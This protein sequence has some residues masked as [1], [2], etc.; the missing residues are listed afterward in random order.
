MALLALVGC[1]A[2]FDLTRPPDAPLDPD[3]PISC[4]LATTHDEDGDGVFDA[5]DNCPTLANADQANTLETEDGE[6]ADSVGDVCDPN[7]TRSGDT[8]VRAVM[9]DKTSDTTT[10]QAQGQWLHQ[11]DV[12][13]YEPVTSHTEQVLAVDSRAMPAPPFTIETNVRFVAGPIPP[14]ATYFSAGIELFPDDETENVWCLIESDSASGAAQRLSAFAYVNTN[15]QNAYSFAMNKD[16]R[17]VATYVPDADGHPEINCRVS[18]ATGSTSSTATADSIR[19]TPSLALRAANARTEFASLVI[20][21][22]TE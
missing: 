2:V 19:G 17:L 5:C 1:D 9:F 14:S 4:E 22:R 11:G 7:P 3:A 10:F 8:I 12:Y 16:Q 15:D 13:R 6:L 20:Y 21:G 18:S